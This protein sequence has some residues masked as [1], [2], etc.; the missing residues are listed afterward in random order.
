MARETDGRT[1]SPQARKHFEERRAAERA[2][3]WST[4]YPKQVGKARLMKLTPELLA[5]YSD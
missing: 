3:R 2:K 1:A 4:A 5:H